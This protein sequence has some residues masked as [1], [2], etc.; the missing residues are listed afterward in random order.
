MKSLITYGRPSASRSP[1]ALGPAAAKSTPRCAPP[2]RSCRRHTAAP[3]FDHADVLARRASR[4]Q[5]N[6]SKPRRALRH[7]DRHIRGA[8]GAASTRPPASATHPVHLPRRSSI[9]ALYGRRILERHARQARKGLQPTRMGT[10]RGLAHMPR[11][12]AHPRIRAQ[13]GTHFPRATSTAPR[14]KSLP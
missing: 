14:P 11:R 4:P 3:R 13:N 8:S 2:L 6:P 9:S 5:A 10:A 1:L 7:A 12:K